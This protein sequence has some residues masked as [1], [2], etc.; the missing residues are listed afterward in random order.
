M[1]ETHRWLGAISALFGAWVFVSV[2]VFGTSG[3]H[4]W[5]DLVVGAAIVV[6]AGYSAMQATA[7]ETANP[8]ASALAGLLGLWTI[9]A[10][11]VYGATG[12]AMWS[13]VVSGI[14][15][16]VLSGYNAY[17]AREAAGASTS[18]TPGT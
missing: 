9:A 15:V 8:W 6:L 3:A 13:S 17:E 5:N 16:A 18:G 2:F 10:P 14:V 12:M 7:S 1:S 11:F 4:F